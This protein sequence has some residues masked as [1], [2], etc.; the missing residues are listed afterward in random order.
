MENIEED[1]ENFPKFN[2]WEEYLVWL[3][4]NYPELYSGGDWIEENVE[5]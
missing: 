4:E 1:L 5:K 3:K 2:T